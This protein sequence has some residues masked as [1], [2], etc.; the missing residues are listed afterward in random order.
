MSAYRVLWSRD[1]PSEQQREFYSWADEQHEWSALAWM[2]DTEVR[3]VSSSLA[4]TRNQRVRSA[5]QRGP[6]EASGARLAAAEG[7]AASALGARGQRPSG[8][9]R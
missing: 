1:M 6:A 2:A 9:A 5:H 4:Q 3:E 7:T 8:G